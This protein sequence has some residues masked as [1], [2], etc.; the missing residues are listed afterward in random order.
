VYTNENFQETM[1]SIKDEY[2][3]KVKNFVSLD[4][5]APVAEDRTPLSTRVKKQTK[6]FLA[7]EAKERKI[8][9]STLAAAILDS[10]VAEQSKGGNK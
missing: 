4:Q 2:M 10:F 5:I 8:T 6:S 9:V 7:K 1:R 3:S